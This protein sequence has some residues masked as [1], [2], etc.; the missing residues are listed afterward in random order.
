MASLSAGDLLGSCANAFLAIAD[1]EEYGTRGKR[2]LRLTP[3][4]Q[5]SAFDGWHIRRAL[6]GVWAHA[7]SAV[8][9]PRD[10]PAQGRAGIH[11]KQ[12]TV[13]PAVWRRSSFARSCD[14][15]SAEEGSLSARGAGK[16]QTRE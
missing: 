3:L 1:T 7:F 13:I 5:Q 6:R 8:P 2:D 10:L 12:R 14:T 9:F 15:L 11:D 4:R 16:N